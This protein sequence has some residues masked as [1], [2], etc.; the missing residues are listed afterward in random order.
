MSTRRG[1]QGKSFLKAK[2]QGRQTQQNEAKKKNA[3]LSAYMNV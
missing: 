1:R 3:S 2:F